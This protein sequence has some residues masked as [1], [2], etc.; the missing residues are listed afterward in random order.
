[1]AA[2]IGFL[3]FIIMSIV[4]IWQYQSQKK[5]HEEKIKN[6]KEELKK[7]FQR[8]KE[9]LKATHEREIQNIIEKYKKKLKISKKQNKEN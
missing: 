5:L 9:L 2:P 7:E 1:M 8:E 6:I 3:V 4:C